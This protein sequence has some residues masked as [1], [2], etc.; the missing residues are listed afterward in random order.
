MTA[1]AVDRLPSG[2]AVQDWTANSLQRSPSRR[3]PP[4]VSQTPS[5][6]PATDRV[7]YMRGERSQQFGIRR[8]LNVVFPQVHASRDACFPPATDAASFV[9]DQPLRTSRIPPKERGAPPS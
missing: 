6:S 7:A 3:A 4:A 1:L 8:V 5:L 2:C 9:W